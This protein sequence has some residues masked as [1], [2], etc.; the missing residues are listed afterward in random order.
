MNNSMMV[1]NPYWHKNTW[2]FDDEAAGLK[3]EPFVAYVP[4]M[5]DD[6]VKG[7]RG[8]RKG[9][10]LLFSAS[11]FPTYQVELEWIREESGGNWYRMKGQIKEGWLCP[12]LFKYFKE[13]PKSIFVK[14]E[15]IKKGLF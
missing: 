15:P 13:A 14:A 5:I 11:P 7:I 9:F 6:L 10:K 3:Q 2:V 1:I 8:A 4:E 12:A